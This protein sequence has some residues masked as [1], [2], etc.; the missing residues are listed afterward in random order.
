MSADE[1]ILF[2]KLFEG[3]FAYVW[4]TLRRLG[5]VEKDR[6]DVAQEVFVVVYQKLGEFDRT[7]PVRP[8]LFGISY[9][10]ALRHR[11]LARHKGEV[12]GDADAPSSN[13]PQTLTLAR[14]RER[15]VHHAIERIDLH[16]RGV[17]VLA[18]IDG[19]SAPE[20]AETLE[21]PL[22]TVYSRLRLARA[23]FAQAVADLGEEGKV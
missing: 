23:D 5:V 3:E 6:R 8:W 22:N 13:N 21:I 12:L 4:N 1:T 14:E 18:E 16:R 10:I 17:F 9:R 15:L 7:R 19:L 11:S 2:R 20:I